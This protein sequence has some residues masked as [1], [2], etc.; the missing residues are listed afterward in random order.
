MPQQNNPYPPLEGV[1]TGDG[2]VTMNSNLNNNK[3][4][5]VHAQLR[6]TATATMLPDA[7]SGLQQNKMEKLNKKQKN[8]KLLESLLL[9]NDE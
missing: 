5:D 3:F 2:N 7:S 9:Q 1:A 8:T 4:S 6:Y